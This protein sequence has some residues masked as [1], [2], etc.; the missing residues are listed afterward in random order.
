MDVK[1][2]CDSIGIELNGWKAKL[3]DVIRKAES[4]PDSEKDIVAPMVRDLNSMVD[5]LRERLK[6]LEKE[7]PSQ[8]SS[9]EAAIDDTMTQIRGKWKEVW[10][11]M[12][13]QEYGIGGA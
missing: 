6:S 13:E 11:V 2:Y 8:W 7:C 3:Y 9:D 5:D 1:S 12:G 4:L 10:G